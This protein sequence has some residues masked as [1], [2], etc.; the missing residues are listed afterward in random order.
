[1]GH[2]SQT[3]VYP[4]NPFEPEFTFVIFIHYKPRIA[5]AILD[6]KWKK[7]IWCGLNIEEKCHVLVNEFHENVLSKTI[8]CRKIKSAFRYEKWCINASWGLKG[9]TQS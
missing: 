9:L 3:S 2:E 1:M 5:I 8:G 7:M 4:L 6:L